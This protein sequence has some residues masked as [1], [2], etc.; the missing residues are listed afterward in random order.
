[1]KLFLL[2]SILFLV[3]SPLYATDV[4]VGVSIGVDQPG[5]YGQIN[6]GD[7]PS[8][9]LIY[10]DPLMI[11]PI[12]RGVVYEPIY[13]YVPPGHARHWSKHCRSYNACGR[14]V[15]FVQERWYNRVYAPR[16]NKHEHEHRHEGNHGGD[17]NQDHGKHGRG[18]GRGH[19]KD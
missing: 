1:M 13:L 10:R 3:T 9:I 11:S 5:F 8:P 7:F 19:K 2:A 14:P 18:E 4:D 17:R 15:Y 12:R 6:I 16:H